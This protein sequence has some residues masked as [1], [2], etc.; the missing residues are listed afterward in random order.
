M[1]LAETYCNNCF[2]DQFRG[3][4]VG[5]AGGIRCFGSR[6]GVSFYLL[7][8]MLTT[9]PDLVSVFAAFIDIIAMFLH[10]IFVRVSSWAGAVPRRS[11]DF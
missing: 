5:G 2:Q 7:M 10:L 3:V 1:I 11:S 9:F 6:A 8:W 4:G